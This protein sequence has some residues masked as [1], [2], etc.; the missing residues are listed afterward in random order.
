MKVNHFKD[1]II[2]DVRQAILDAKHNPHNLKSDH[3]LIT[4]AVRAV[5]RQKFHL[6]K[7]LQKDQILEICEVLLESGDWQERT[8]AFQWSFQIRRAYETSDFKRFEGWLAH[9][10]S[11]WGSCDDFC[12]HA[13]G[14]FIYSYPKH[15]STVKSWTDSSNR[16]FRRAAAVVL[17]YGIRRGQNLHAGF[18]IADLLLMDEDDLVQKGYGWMLKEISKLEPLQVFNYVYQRKGRMPRTSLR[19]AIEKLPP[20]LRASAMKKV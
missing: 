1:A 12:T 11:G 16:W 18:E 20:D 14:Y 15:I 3:I 4:A 8:I 13:F 6:V 5:A 19:Y 10:V 2:Q 9:Y 17:I 7:S